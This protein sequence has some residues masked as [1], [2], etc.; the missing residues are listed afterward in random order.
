[1]NEEFQLNF[2]QTRAKFENLKDFHSTTNFSPSIK[3]IKN[4]SLNQSNDDITYSEKNLIPIRKA[5]NPPN[6]TNC[7]SSPI[8]FSTIEEE[9]HYDDNEE[10]IKNNVKKSIERFNKLGIILPINHQSKQEIDINDD[11]NK[12]LFSDNEA[13]TEQIIDDDSEYSLISYSTTNN[14]SFISSNK[15]NSN[16]FESKEKLFSDI[17]SE[18]RS[19]DNFKRLAIKSGLPSDVG[20]LRSSVNKKKYQKIRVSDPNHSCHEN[21]KCS[22]LIKSQTEPNQFPIKEEDEKGNN[23]KQK[24]I[25][26]VSTNSSSIYS[27][28]EVSS[29]I[30]IP[31]IPFYDVGNEKENE[32]LREMH[33]VVYEFY[34]VE[35]SFVELL[36]HVGVN[37]PKYLEECQKR[38]GY[39]WLTP[40]K[41]SH[42]PGDVITRISNHLQMILAVHEDFLNLFEIKLKN[43]DSINPNFS[44]VFK[45]ADYLKICKNF[46]KEK[47]LLTEE[48]IQFLKENSE[49][50]I[51]T[52]TFEQDELT[53]QQ[54]QNNNN[55][56][57]NKINN[58][59]KTNRNKHYII[60]Q[61]DNI[62]QNL[63]QYK[64]LMI[65]YKKCLKEN[66]TE[67]DS[68]D[69]ALKKLEEVSDCVNQYL[70]GADNNELIELHRRLERRFDV[71]EPGRKL[72]HKGELYR[73]TRKM[74]KPRY[75]I[76]FSDYL[77]ICQYPSIGD[78][79]DRFHKISVEDIQIII[80]DH[81]DYET[82]F[83][84]ISPQKSSSFASKNKLERD[85]WVQRISEAKTKTLNNSFNNNKNKLSENLIKSEEENKPQKIE[86]STVAPEW[87][88][89]NKTTKC[90][91]I[92]CET[93][94]NLIKRRHHCRACGWIICGKCVGYAPVVNL[95]WEREIVC[96]ECFEK[97]VI[98]FERGI[99]FT[100]SK[101]RIIES[102][103]EQLNKLPENCLKKYSV[104]DLSLKILYEN[105]DRII[106]LSKLFI[107]PKNGIRKRIIV[108]GIDSTNNSFPSGLVFFRN[109]KGIITQRWARL[110]DNFWLNFYEAE[111]DDKPS[112]SF[113]IYGYSVTS[114]ETEKDGT[115]IELTHH[116][117]IQTERKGDEIIFCVRHAGS[118]NNWLNSLNEMLRIDELK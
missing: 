52:R 25:S 108:Q 17:L 101:V 74:P 18:M 86:F 5:P 94:F 2:S 43:W 105:G 76:L 70:V 7:L 58:L 73:Y 33:F 28:S 106:P 16:N 36:Q 66:S 15:R 93:K 29:L 10:N 20:T 41:G 53:D 117:Q 64:N 34:K 48:F 40:S 51:A 31:E 23:K 11:E 75:L 115:I 19:K 63:V 67:F 79:F 54:Q 100:S 85:I 83:T 90:L 98:A 39:K 8:S 110:L 50:A 102:S 92:G 38:N 97:I 32:R 87:M 82:E 96:P 24:T 91:I 56:S 55:S 6:K 4:T 12:I 62:H 118:A 1:M 65:R 69:K 9:K 44:E 81:V 95:E 3:H 14:D 107:M 109:S 45:N 104:N 37:Y 103:S 84:L 42:S 77:L 61:L 116:N 49:L 22:R 46:L 78:N 30:E 71:F 111:F 99:L 72:L 13:E 47:R 60:M 68:A 35:K 57:T 26:I 21:I 89:D 114:K 113:F 80:K 27:S 59:I 112:E 88:R